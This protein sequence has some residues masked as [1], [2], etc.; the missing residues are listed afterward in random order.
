MVTVNS[1]AR[2]L[3]IFYRFGLGSAAIIGPLILV[4]FSAFGPDIA[5]VLG[6]I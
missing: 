4:S 5:Y 3:V 1:L 2:R 6:I